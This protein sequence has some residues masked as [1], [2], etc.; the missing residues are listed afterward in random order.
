MLITVTINFEASKFPFQFYISTFLTSKTKLLIT[1]GENTESKGFIYIS[2]MMAVGLQALLFMTF[3]DNSWKEEEE[4]RPS[5][6]IC[7][8][9]TPTI[10]LTQ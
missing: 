2:N 5:T 1:E 7:Y 6:S 10:K 4:E 3:V 9:L 8:L